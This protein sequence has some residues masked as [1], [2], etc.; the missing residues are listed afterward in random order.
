MEEVPDASKLRHLRV[1]TELTHIDLW[2]DERGH[3][4]R[5]SNPEAQFE[6]IRER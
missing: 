6:A 3:L 2:V 4:E 5:V 1:S